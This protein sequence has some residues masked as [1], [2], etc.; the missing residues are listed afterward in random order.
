[1]SWEREPGCR[2]GP[3]APQRIA[4]LADR[5]LPA[6]ACI[7]ACFAKLGHE[8]IISATMAKMLKLRLGVADDP[9]A[10]QPLLN[11]CLGAVLQQA[12][13]LIAE[14]LQAL[15][16]GSAPV[17]PQSVAAF[18]APAVKAAIL[19]LDAD[20]AAVRSSYKA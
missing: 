14:V 17:G 1:M 20:G 15:V 10:L 3:A 5:L 6:R 9:A 2:F 16:K 19:A 13:P 18:Q 12:E 8:P 7:V 4:E 11:D